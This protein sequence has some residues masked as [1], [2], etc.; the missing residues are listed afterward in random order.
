MFDILIKDGCVVDGTGL[1]AHVQDIGIKGDMISAVGILD[2]RSSRDVVEA[3]GQ[4]V[5]RGLLT[6]M[7]TLIL[8]CWSRRLEEGK[9]PQGVTTEVCGNCGVSGAPLSGPALEQRRKSLTGLGIDLTWSTMN[10]YIALL[11]RLQLYCNVVPLIGHG[12]V[13]GSVFGYE[14]RKPLPEEMERMKQ[15]VRDGM[16][17]GAWGLSS[18]LFYPPG[19]YAAAEEIICLAGIVSAC[20][21]V[22]ASI[23]AMKKTRLLKQL[24]RRCASAGK[25]VFQFRSHT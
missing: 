21:G 15:L 23:Y 2:A 25:P 17:A 3:Q 4:L 11:E 20:G 1:P 18:G 9:V 6:C 7:R 5:C 13:R 16:D 14:N 8:I 10:E 19:V 24:K 12:N 22:Y